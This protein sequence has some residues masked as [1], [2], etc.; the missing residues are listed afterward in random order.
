WRPPCAWFN[1]TG[2]SLAGA[3]LDAG[4]VAPCPARRRAGSACPAAVRGRADTDRDC[5]LSVLF[6]YECVPHC[7][8]VPRTFAR[9]PLRPAAVPGR[10]IDTVGAPQSAGLAHEA[11]RGLRLVPHP[12]ELRHAGRATSAPARHR[13][14][15]CD[16]APLAARAGL[17]VET[18]AVGG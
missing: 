15:G 1:H 14:L 3:R 9:Y 5:R 6:A 18:G 10:R 7:E 12:M 11:T 16:D 17:G 4:R 8:C 2:D 13:S